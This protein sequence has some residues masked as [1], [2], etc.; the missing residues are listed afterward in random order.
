MSKQLRAVGEARR[1][2]SLAE[3]MA[4]D[5]D[6]TLRRWRRYGS[7]RP[8]DAY[9]SRLGTADRD[10]DEVRAPV[11]PAVDNLLRR[12]SGEFLAWSALGPET[13]VLLGDAGF[14]RL[15]GLLASHPNGHVREA[16]CGRLVRLAHTRRVQPLVLRCLDPV[17]QVREIAAAGV[18][19]VLVIEPMALHRSDYAVLRRP[20]AL[21]L[22]PDLARRAAHVQSTDRYV[23]RRD[24]DR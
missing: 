13:A 17:E 8:I 10:L 7:M 2:L 6:G 21:R 3:P 4:A 1:L 15:L 16:A 18:A 5:L 22:V 11:T 9:Y 24:A 20:R 14:E 19:E 23:S 12:E